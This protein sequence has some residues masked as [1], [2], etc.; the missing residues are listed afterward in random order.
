MAPMGINLYIQTA[1]LSKSEP[2]MPS[3]WAS[4][5]KQKANSSQYRPRDGFKGGR[6]FDVPLHDNDQEYACEPSHPLFEQWGV[7]RLC[8]LDC[9]YAGTMQ[10]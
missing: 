6:L 3:D 1:N 8:V 2:R 10:R 5:Q 7:I 4:P 9:R